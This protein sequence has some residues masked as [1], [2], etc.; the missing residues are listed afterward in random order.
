LPFPYFADV[1]RAYDELIAEGKIKRRS[2]QEEVEQDKGLMTRR[3][4][5]YVFTE[6]DPKIG[7]LEK[8]EGNNSLGYSVDLLIATDG[9]YWDV[10][11]DSNGMAMPVD[12]GPLSDPALIPRWRRP[13][14]ELAGL[15]GDS[16]STIPPPGTVIPY[17]ED[18]S[19]EFGVA[20]NETYTES[21]AAFDPGM[22]SVHSQRCAWDYYVKYMPWPECLAKHVNEFRAVYGLLPVSTTVVVASQAAQAKPK[23]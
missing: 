16:G 2:S 8:T 17:D 14:K 11:T 18:K 7:I 12:G 9:T 1:Q 20:C 15:D 4:G 19:I 10:A 6:R 13:T 23:G 22:I 21:G 5:Y 3:A